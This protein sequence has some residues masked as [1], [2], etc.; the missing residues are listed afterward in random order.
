MVTGP[1]SDANSCPK[2]IG[3]IRRV[4]AMAND[5][6]RGPLPAKTKASRPAPPHEP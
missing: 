1:R 6:I 4:L 3:S 2:N 5:A